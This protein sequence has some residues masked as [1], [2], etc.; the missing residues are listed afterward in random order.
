MV[1]VWPVI[2]AGQPAAD[3]ALVNE[4]VVV[5]V[6]DTVTVPV[7]PVSVVLTVDEPFQ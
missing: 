7:V 2:V 1:T 4:Y 5:L 6:G 3:V